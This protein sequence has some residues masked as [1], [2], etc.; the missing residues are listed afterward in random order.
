[1]KWV[2]GDQSSI[3]CAVGGTT[4][5]TFACWREDPDA[6]RP[7]SNRDKMLLTSPPTG[8]LLLYDIDDDYEATLGSDLGTTHGD[9]YSYGCSRWEGIFRGLLEE[10]RAGQLKREEVE[11]AVYDI[12]QARAWKPL[13]RGVDSITGFEMLEIMDG[14]PAEVATELRRGAGANDTFGEDDLDGYG[15]SVEEDFMDEDGSEEE[16]Y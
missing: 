15:E 11:P 16:D 12:D 2:L 14:N 4:I 10:L 7:G 3:L 1:M 13:K 5:G 8:K 9:I 6:P